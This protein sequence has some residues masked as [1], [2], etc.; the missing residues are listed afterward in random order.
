MLVNEISPP[1]EGL[2][3]SMDRRSRHRY[4]I[5]QAVSYKLAQGKVP[6]GVGRTIN[7][8]ATGVLFTTEQALPKGREVQVSVNWPVLLHGSCALKFVASGPIVW[9]D[10]QQAAIRIKRYEFR[11]RGTRPE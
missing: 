3:N 1:V 4:A 8:G 9:S 6:G 7:I 2:E 10:G 11:T 5:T